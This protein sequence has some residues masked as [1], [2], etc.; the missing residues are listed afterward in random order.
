AARLVDLLDREVHARDLG[1]AEEGE[2]AGLR[3]QRTHDESVT[4][5]PPTLRT[6]RQRQ[7][8]GAG[9]RRDTHASALVIHRYPVSSVLPHRTH[10]PRGGVVRETYRRNVTGT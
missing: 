4:A 7:Q 5:G 10:L 3:Q 1:R 6:G 2:R 8:R 9:E